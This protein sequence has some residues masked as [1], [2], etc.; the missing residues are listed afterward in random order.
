MNNMSNSYDYGYQRPN[1]AKGLGEYSNKMPTINVICVA[2]GVM[3]RKVEK[4]FVT[5]YEILADGEVFFRSANQKEAE[6]MYLDFSGISKQK[7]A[8]LCEKLKNETARAQEMA[9]MAAERKAFEIAHLQPV[10]TRCAA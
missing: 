3:L 6:R 1:G 10:K 8:K 7:F 2:D 5:S 9:K 4:S